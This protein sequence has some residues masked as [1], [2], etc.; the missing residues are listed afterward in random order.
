[1]IN[2]K[3]VSIIVP[4]YNVEIYLEETLESL[5]KQ[6][7]DSYEIILVDDGSTDS[8]SD[9]I[10]QY[11]KKNNNIKYIYQENKGP[12]AARNKGIE[13]AIGEYIIFCD[14]DDILPVD[15]VEMRYNLIKSSDSD[16]VVVAT[17]IYDGLNKKIIKSHV[18]K[19][20]FK[21]IIKN[22]EL[23]WMMGPCNKIYKKSLLD[24]IRYTDKINYG[25]DQLFV[26]ETY[27]K[28]KKIYSSKY[29]GYYYRS[30]GENGN[31]LTQQVNKNPLKIMKNINYLWENVCYLINIYIHNDIIANNLKANYFYRLVNVNIWSVLKE[32]SVGKCKKNRKEVLNE[33]NNFSNKLS[34]DIIYR[35]GF[36]KK[37]IFD[38]LIDNNSKKMKMILELEIILLVKMSYY[39]TKLRANINRIYRR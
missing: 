12:G 4:V 15:S 33:L 27:L 23:L 9:I 29:V 5:T 39:L 36:L 8:S 22:P 35:L 13:N 31:S 32:I 10:K 17:A 14:S 1:M 20:G 37:C 30:R 2:E 21:D 28:A 26:F 24:Y 6:S 16:I 38:I 25:E 34:K 7:F 3:K 11:I 19:D 18:L